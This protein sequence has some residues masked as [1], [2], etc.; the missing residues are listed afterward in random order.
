MYYRVGRT[1]DGRVAWSAR[2]T[3]CKAGAGDD[4]GQC[5]ACWHDPVHSE[6]DADDWWCSPPMTAA[7]YWQ[8]TTFVIVDI[9][10]SVDH[11]RKLSVTLFRIQMNE[12]TYT[13][14]L[15]F[16]VEP[17]EK[18]TTFKDIFPAICNIPLT[19][20][21]SLGFSL[22][23]IVHWMHQSVQRLSKICGRWLA[24][25]SML[26]SGLPWHSTAGTTWR[27]RPDNEDEERFY[28]YELH[29]IA[30][31]GNF[32]HRSSPATISPVFV[33]SDMLNA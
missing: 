8:Q 18:C 5:V 6:L 32:R 14:S 7:T 4:R 26:G 16:P 2:R 19:G 13:W 9:I 3:T 23:T 24:A 30:D 28:R 1:S 27:L 31:R 15:Y 21:T 29:H 20:N 12:L 33:Q 25:L 11:C 10:Q 22:H 17:L